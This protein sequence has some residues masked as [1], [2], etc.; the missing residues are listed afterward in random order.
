MKKQTTKEQDDEIKR[1]RREN[2]DWL[3]K[4]IQK[5]FDISRSTWDRIAQEMK[6]EKESFQSVYGIDAKFGEKDEPKN[7]ALSF[8]E[9]RKLY[10]LRTIIEDGMKNIVGDCFHE[11]DDF[12]QDLG[13]DKLTWQKIE[14]DPE[15]LKY[16]I[17][18]RGKII[19]ASPEMQEKAKKTIKIL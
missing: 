13:I 6:Y 4:D 17:K 16:Q 8:E 14:V 3:I 18:I 5:K 2:P 12:R 10:D 1:F 9:F 11:S 19:W 15:F 7:K